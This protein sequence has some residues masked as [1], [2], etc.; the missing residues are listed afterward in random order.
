MEGE[1][2]E[3]QQR[4][5]NMLDEQK[6]KSCR[7]SQK[8]ERTKDKRDGTKR[9]IPQQNKLQTEENMILLVEKLILFITNVINCTDQAKHKTEKKI[10][11]VRGAEKFLGF[12]EESWENINKRLETGETRNPSC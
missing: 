1:R 8:C 7:S 4:K 3:K 10:I 5:S 9:E 12:K 6:H 2:C 11:I